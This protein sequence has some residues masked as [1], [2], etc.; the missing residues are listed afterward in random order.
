M[1]FNIMG[2][3]D[4]LFMDVFMLEVFCCLS[5]IVF[6]LFMVGGGICDFI[7]SNGKS[8]IAFEVASAYF[9]SGVDK[10]L[11]GSD[12]VYVVEDWY[13]FGKVNMGKMSVE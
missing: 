4:L 13:V 9:V 5:E 1:F 2:Y 7:D 10:V 8:Y 11:I 12:V 6:V 3:R